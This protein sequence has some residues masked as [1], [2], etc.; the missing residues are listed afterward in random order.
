[1]TD[2]EKLVKETEC[3]LEEIAECGFVDDIKVEDLAKKLVDLR[4]CKVP[5]DMIVLSKE[6]YNKLR[7]RPTNCAYIDISK[8]SV[9]ECQKEIEDAVNERTIAIIKDIIGHRFAYYMKDE[10]NGTVICCADYV[11]DDD[12]VKF[13][14]EKYKVEV[15]K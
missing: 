4:I 2:R 6:E 11:V 1:M 8:D 13:L 7:S 3:A 14:K 12:D 15:K 10:T 9:K 5:T